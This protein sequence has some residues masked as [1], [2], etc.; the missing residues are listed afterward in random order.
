M[1]ECQVDVVV[2]LVVVMVVVMV[3]VIVV[4]MAIVAVVCGVYSLFVFLACPP[5]MWHVFSLTSVT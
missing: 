2:V 3:V 1:V 4:A 5:C